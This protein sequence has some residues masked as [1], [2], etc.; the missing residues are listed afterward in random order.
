LFGAANGTTKKIKYKIHCGFQRPPIDDTHTTT[1]QKQVYAMDGDMDE[2][3]KWRESMGE[4][5]SIILTAIEL[6]E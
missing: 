1:S 2:R 5:K 3:R 6:E 4:Y